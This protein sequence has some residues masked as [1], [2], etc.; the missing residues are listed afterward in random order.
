MSTQTGGNAPGSAAIA[1][2]EESWTRAS[3]AEPART[4]PSV[5]PDRKIDYVMFRPRERWRVVSIEVLDERVAS[6]HR[7]VV[8]VLELLP[9]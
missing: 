8:A 2:L 3:G 9:R 6:D 1:L 7:P 4:W 5:A